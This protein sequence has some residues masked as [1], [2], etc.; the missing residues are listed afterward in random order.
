MAIAWVLFIVALGVAMFGVVIIKPK[1]ER[2][3]P[4]SLELTLMV[5]TARVVKML[6]Q[7]LVIVAFLFLSLVVVAYS[8]PVG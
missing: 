1:A 7:M 5:E 8:E 6:C 2:H 3:L 4:G